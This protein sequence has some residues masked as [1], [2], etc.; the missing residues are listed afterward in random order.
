MKKKT[1]LILSFLATAFLI[2]AVVQACVKP[3]DSASGTSS[4][5]SEPEFT[6]SGEAI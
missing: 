4:S 1:L 5:D 2:A 3:G 6:L